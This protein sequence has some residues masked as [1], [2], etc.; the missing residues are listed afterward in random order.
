[1]T[2][3]DMEVNKE[4]LKY[5]NTYTKSLCKNYI[6]FSEYNSFEDEY[7]QRIDNYKIDI[8]N[9]SKPFTIKLSDVNKKQ[10]EVK[11]AIN[12]LII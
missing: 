1:M 4:A 11:E 3:E 10:I 5:F 6:F 8:W 9:D 2:P 12:K 7:Q